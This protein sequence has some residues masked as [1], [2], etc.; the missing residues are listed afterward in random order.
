MIKIRVNG[1]LNMNPIIVTTRK[2]MQAIGITVLLCLPVQ[3]VQA[4]D[5]LAG[6]WQHESNPV[7]LAM[8]P[9]EGA[10]IMVRNDDRPDRVGFKVVTDLVETGKANQWSG[11]VF[12]AQLGEYRDA[13]ITLKNE[14][15]MAFTVK[16]GFVRRT[17]E[18]QRVDAVPAGPTAE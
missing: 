5:A 6:F 18:W 8:Q 13:T 14:N 9:D 1:A 15:R 16:V 3:F 17:V 7:W 2:V 10:A 12:A 11:Q 4:E